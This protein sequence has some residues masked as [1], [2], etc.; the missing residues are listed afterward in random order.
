MTWEEL[1]DITPGMFLALNRELRKMEDARAEDRS[2]NS[3]FLATVI[4]QT[5]L[6][7]FGGEG[8]NFMGDDATVKAAAK[9]AAGA[10]PDEY[11]A[12]ISIDD[13]RD[14]FKGLADQAKQRVGIGATGL[15][16]DQ[17]A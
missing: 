6:G 11:S 15:N 7:F 17:A 4:S 12:A 10:Q 14:Y 3:R 2:L 13:T 8:I 9:A 5:V 16:P 1:L